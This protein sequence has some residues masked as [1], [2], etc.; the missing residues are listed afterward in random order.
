MSAYSET[1]LCTANSPKFAIFSI[2]S[3]LILRKRRKNEENIE[4]NFHFQQCLET[5]KGQYFEKSKGELNTGLRFYSSSLQFFV[6]LK[7]LALCVYG[8]YA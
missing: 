6:S 4:R 7:Y 3:P 2:Y 8:E 1:I 5:L